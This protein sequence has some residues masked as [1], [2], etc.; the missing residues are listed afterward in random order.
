[1]G[2]GGPKGSPFLGA[3][4]ESGL[5]RSPL[6]GLELVEAGEGGPTGSPLTLWFLGGGG[7]VGSPLAGAPGGLVGVVGKGRRDLG[8]TL[9]A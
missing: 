3:T 7:P 6:T 4:S 2:E 8:R 1:M 9:P 5:G